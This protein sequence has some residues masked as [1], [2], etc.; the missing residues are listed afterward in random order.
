MAASAAREGAE[1]AGKSAAAGPAEAAGT[2]VTTDAGARGWGLR[3]GVRHC[4]LQ[5]LPAHGLGLQAKVQWQTL[6]AQGP[7]VLGPGRQAQAQE[8]RV[9]QVVLRV[10]QAQATRVTGGSGG[11]QC[12]TVLSTHVTRVTSRRYRSKQVLNTAV[13]TAGNALLC[14]RTHQARPSG[15]VA[16]T[17]TS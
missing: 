3:T 9:Q 12:P 1:V 10:L 13:S 15:I 5:E 8:V 6:V 17:D 4:V 2:E 16:G 14:N 7:T 11:G